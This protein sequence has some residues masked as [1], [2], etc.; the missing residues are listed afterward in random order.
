MTSVMDRRTFLAGTGA[1][2]LAAPLAAEAQRAK[3]PLIGVLSPWSVSLNPASQ[4]EPFER[5]LRELGWTAGTTIIVEQRYA[6]GQT[7]RLPILAAELVQMKVDV[8]VANGLLA[9][10]ASR[11]ATSTIPIVMSAAGDPVREGF[12]QSLAHPGGNVTGL[13]FLAQG[14]IEPK[15]L[16]LLREVV[17]GL[18]RVGVLANRSSEQVVADEIRAAAFTLGLQVQTFEVSR[19]EELPDAFR[20]MERSAVGAVLVRADPLVLDPH[21][22]QSVAL[23]L[24]HRLPAIYPW[25]S[26]PAVGGLMSYN[27]NIREL[28]RRSAFYVDRILKGAKPGDLPVEQPTKFE[29]V[30]N[31]KTAKALGLTIPPSLLG[32]A[33]EVIQ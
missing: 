24:K 16:E 10:R 3:V 15:Q 28:H 33:D 20:A 6:A 13:A 1:V 26:I 32:R 21:S 27:S 25:P 17:P 8:L 19:P 30:I 14:R 18:K 7:D 29:L 22:A 9:I 11:Q 23:A 5:G 4:R 12:V 2:L 31:L